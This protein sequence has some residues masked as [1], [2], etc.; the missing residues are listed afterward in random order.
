MNATTTEHQKNSGFTLIEMVI[1][2]VIFSVATSIGVQSVGDAM[3]R[4]A[5][6]GARRAF[7]AVHAGARAHAVQN[8]VQVRFIADAEVDSL[9]VSAGDSVVTALSLVDAIKTGQPPGHQQQYHEHN[10]ARAAASA[11]TATEDAAE[12]SLPVLYDLIEIVGLVPVAFPGVL[13]VT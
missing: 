4:G 3:E 8:G 13:A 9:W 10:T 7:T 12:A 6:R 2:I 1:A 11:A 5:V